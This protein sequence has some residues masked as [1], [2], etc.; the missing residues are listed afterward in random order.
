MPLKTVHYQRL[1][2][3]ESEDEAPPSHVQLNGTSHVK[4]KYMYSRVT[5]TMLFTS[6]LNHSTRKSMESH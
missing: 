3:T 4:G 2:T 6:W 5:G 1:E